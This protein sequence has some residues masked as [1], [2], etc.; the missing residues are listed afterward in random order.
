[1]F[2][3]LVRFYL[4]GGLLARIHPRIYAPYV[5]YVPS[6]TIDYPFGQVTNI[7]MQRVCELNKQ[8]P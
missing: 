1:M 8:A 2:S 5:S 6:R 4:G 3:Y 7:Q